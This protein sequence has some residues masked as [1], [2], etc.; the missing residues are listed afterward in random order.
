MQWQTIKTANAKI[1]ESEVSM[2][3]DVKSHNPLYLIFMLILSIFAIAL[4]SFDLIFTVNQNERTIIEYADTLICGF[5]FL[6]FLIILFRSD[7]KLRYI[8]TWGWLDLLSSIPMLGTLRWGRS[9]RIVE[10]F[11]CSVVSVRLECLPRLYW[12]GGHKAQCLLQY[13]LQ[14]FL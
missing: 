10:S 7:E 12:N 11:V 6:D 13:L 1:R 9:A 2:D 3:E 8:I 5:F 4:L 14:S